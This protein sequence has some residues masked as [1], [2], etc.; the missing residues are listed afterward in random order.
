MSKNKAF[1]VK[2]RKKGLSMRNIGNRLGIARSTLSNW[3]KNI[4]LTDKQKE[5]L[6]KQWGLG[7]IKA[8]KK[9]SE[10]HKTQK[11][12]RLIEARLTAQ[13]VLDKLNL[14]NSNII[15]LALAMLYLGEGIKSSDDT[16]IGNSD[17]LILKTFVHILINYYKI[18]PAKIKC[19][20]NLRADQ[21]PKKIRSFWS[22]TLNLPIKNFTY[23]N[24][25]KRTI[26]SKTYSY[27]KGVCL[28]R[29]GNVAIQRKLLNIS[30]EFCERIIKIEPGA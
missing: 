22:K 7:L 9:A 18:N 20:L 15:E 16:A 5:K 27:Y 14:G 2:L 29:C 11:E 8:R 1:A 28:V 13:Q 25:D 19:G 4:D 6:K 26:G 10:W 21:N 23:I 17:P 30:K 24:I 12:K 3:F